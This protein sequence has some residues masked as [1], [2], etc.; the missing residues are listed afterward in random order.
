[1]PRFFVEEKPQGRVFLGGEEGRHGAKALR[2]GL[3]QCRDWPELMSLLDAFLPDALP[4]DVSPHA[5]AG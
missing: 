3:C 5:G 4:Q 2:H 1:M